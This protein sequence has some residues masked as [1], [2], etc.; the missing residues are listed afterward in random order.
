MKRKIKKVTIGRERY[1]RLNCFREYD[2]RGMV[3]TEINS[4][5]CYRIGRAFSQVIDAKSV[6]LGYD[7]RETSPDFANAISSGIIDAGANVLNIGLSGTEEVYW[8]TNDFKACGGIA[9]TASHNPINWNGLKMVKASSKPLDYFSEFNE[10][11]KLAECQ[12]F[13]DCFGKGEVKDVS[14]EAKTRYIKKVLSFINIQKLKPLK[15]VVNSGNGAA[16]PTLDLLAENIL[17]ANN[18]ID[19]IHLNRSPDYRF[20]KGIPNPILFEN[21]EETSNAVVVNK[22]DLGVAF[23][24]DFDRCF[25]FDENGNYVDGR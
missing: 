1:I 10:V 3:G 21:R 2:V 17:R 15:I 25:F 13:F 18:C 19:L 20:P 7:A 24:G 12:K 4:K 16:G 6:V 11:K 23:D 22:A 14:K 8:A 9:V 5:I